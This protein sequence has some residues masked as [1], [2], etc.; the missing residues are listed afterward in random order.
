MGILK[1]THLTFQIR[2]M[3]KWRIFSS[4]FQKKIQADI[5]YHNDSLQKKAFHN[6]YN[7]PNILCMSSIN[8]FSTSKQLFLLRTKFIKLQSKNTRPY[9]F[10]YGYRVHVCMSERPYAYFAILKQLYSQQQN[11]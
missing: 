2:I 11:K 10:L 3:I 4:H 9:L 7:Q 8:Q 1:S 6:Q 5:D